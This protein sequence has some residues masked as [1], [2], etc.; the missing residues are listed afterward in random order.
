M[1]IPYGIADF[2]SLRTEGNLYV[3]RTDRI[4]VI[5]DLG[6]ALLFLRPRRFG[7]SLWLSTLARYYDLALEDEHR[8][9]F[10]DL[11]IGRES[12]PLAHRYFVLRWDFS[13]IDPDPPPRGVNAGVSSRVE[14]I[15]REIH[16]YLSST[17]RSFVSDYREHLPE[18]EIGED[19][20]SNLDNLLDVIRRTP[21]HLYLLIDEYDNFANEV[22][23]ADQGVYEELVHSDGTFKYL[24][25]WVKAAMAGRGLDR[26]FITGVSPMVMSDVTS[27]MNIARNVY[28][29]PALADLCGFTCAEVDELLAAALRDGGAEFS[30]SD[31]KL[32]MREWYNGYR[33]ALR[34]QERVYNPT[35]VFYFLLNLLEE[36]RPPDQLL[37]SNLGRRRQAGVPGPGRRRPGGRSD[38]LGFFGIWPGDRDRSDPSRAA[39]RGPAAP[40]PLLAEG[41]ARTVGPGH[42]RLRL[43]PLLLRHADPAQ[44]ADPGAD[45][46]AGSAQRG[47][48]RSLRRAYPQ[49]SHASRGFALHRRHPALRLPARRRPRAP[50]RFHRSD[51]LPDLLEP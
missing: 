35:L 36:G 19:A 14:R 7:K 34:V 31:A 8:R 32:M 41:A 28:L 26:L 9:L 12:T 6:K 47:H 24:F 20:F 49:D 22:L 45:G 40:R 29:K 3:D 17:V 11:A 51:A 30:A 42:Q 5:E 21:Y 33:F 2:Y 27:G 18:V 38:R 1:K 23:A 48:A 44:G 15:G 16:R 39:A 46:R 13:Q 4:A 43:L 50:A 25:K 10:G 37:D